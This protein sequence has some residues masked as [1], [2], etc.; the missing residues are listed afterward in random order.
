M[1]LWLAPRLDPRAV[2]AVNDIGALKYLLPNRVVD[3]VGIASPELRREVG[4]A[5]AAGVPWEAAM[6]AAIESRRPD[7]LVIFPTWF[8]AVARDPRF[9][10]VHRL[11][12][13]NNITMGGDEIV[14]YATPWTRYPLVEPAGPGP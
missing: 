7:Y 3:L 8:P 4:R 11:A 12:V 9:P 10:P 14:V 13:P 5:T 6:L 2:L 1:A